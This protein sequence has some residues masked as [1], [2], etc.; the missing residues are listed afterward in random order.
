MEQNETQNKITLLPELLTGK[1][2]PTIKQD[3]NTYSNHKYIKLNGKSTTFLYENENGSNW[4]RYRYC[5]NNCIFLKDTSIVVDANE[6][7]YLYLINVFKPLKKIISYI[8]FAQKIACISKITNII[9][10]D[11]I[12]HTK[13][14]LASFILYKTSYTGTIF[15]M[16]HYNKSNHFFLQNEHYAIANAI[17][18]YYMIK[19]NMPV[20]ITGKIQLIMRWTLKASKNTHANLLHVTQ[21]REPSMPANLPTNDRLNRFALH[22]FAG[23]LQPLKDK[24]CTFTLESGRSKSGPGLDNTSYIQDTAKEMG[25]NLKIKYESFFYHDAFEPSIIE[26]SELEKS[27][28]AIQ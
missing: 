23:M 22:L 27:S 19:K 12:Y 20:C 24:K 7:E 4:P 21:E 1:I 8:R 11:S 18:N 16:T 26:I 10:K 9:L 14:H 17:G 6:R 28:C 25:I 3:L 15:N 13:I 5:G 2:I